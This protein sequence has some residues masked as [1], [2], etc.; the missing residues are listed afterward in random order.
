MMEG[1]GKLTI[2]VIEDI[3][4]KEEDVQAMVCPPT[5]GSTPTN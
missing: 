5:S 4:V 3:E 2:N 1:F